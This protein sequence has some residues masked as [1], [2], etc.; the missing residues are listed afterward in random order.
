MR[1]CETTGHG[2]RLDRSCALDS[3]L[4]ARQLGGLFQAVNQPRGLLGVSEGEG[5]CLLFGSGRDSGLDGRLSDPRLAP[6]AV[7]DADGLAAEAWKDHSQLFAI[8]GVG[9]EEMLDFDRTG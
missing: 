2:R 3:A 1:T 6:G 7:F 8:D 5:S 4:L 9:S